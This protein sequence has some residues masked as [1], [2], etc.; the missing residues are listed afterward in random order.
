MT[1]IKSEMTEIKSGM[2]EIKLEMTEIKSGMTGI[3]FGMPKIKFKISYKDGLSFSY[4][5]II[6][7]V[8]Y[9]K[10]QPSLE[11]KKSPYKG[12]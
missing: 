9:S 1:E 3:K 2:T 5:A 10:G 4:S 8:S 6:A 7:R 11:N 12:A